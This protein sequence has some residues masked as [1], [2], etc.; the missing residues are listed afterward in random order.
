M[1]RKFGK[2][3]ANLLNLFWIKGNKAEG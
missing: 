3:D 2:T 1:V